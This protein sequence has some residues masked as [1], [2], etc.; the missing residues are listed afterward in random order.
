M[1]T[2]NVERALQIHYTDPEE[3]KN[4]DYDFLIL[5]IRKMRGQGAPKKPQAEA[6]PM[7]TLE[8]LGI[9]KPKPVVEFKRRF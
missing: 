9:A 4:E 2:N 1:P 3:L 7:P 6:A 8:E 5:E